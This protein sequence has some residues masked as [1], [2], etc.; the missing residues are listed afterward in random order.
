M[1]ATIA[2][3][4]KFSDRSDHSDHMETTLQRS[5]R[6]RDRKSFGRASGLKNSHSKLRQ[7]QEKK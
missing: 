6:Q 5:Q 1:N 2:E 4:K 3:N 7:I